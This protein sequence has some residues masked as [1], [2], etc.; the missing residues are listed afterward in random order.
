MSTTENT[1]EATAADIGG[2]LGVT[3]RAVRMWV[4]AGDLP[5][6]E[7]G[8][9]DIAWATWL[10]AGRKVSADWRQKP[11]ANVAVAAGWLQAIGHAPKDEDLEVI[12]RLFA[13]NRKSLADAMQ[14]VGA[15]QA[16]M[17]RT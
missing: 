5:R 4:E 7:R 10:A 17:A 16:L 9:F 3:P 8:R 13:R 2:A 12:G 6:L 14:A 11:R 1:F 15:A